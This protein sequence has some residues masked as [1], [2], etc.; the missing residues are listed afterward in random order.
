MGLFLF[1][2]G[3]AYA[4]R[5]A[6]GVLLVA[7]LAL[8]VVTAL[9]IILVPNVT[10]LVTMALA[11]AGVLLIALVEQR[12]ARLAARHEQPLESA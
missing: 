4:V 7:R 2:G 8:L 5:R 10:G 9:V 3:M 1:V 6:H 11:F 12:E